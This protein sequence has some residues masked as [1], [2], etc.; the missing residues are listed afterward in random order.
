MEI[1]VNKLLLDK[2]MNLWVRKNANEFAL[3]KKN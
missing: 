2:A 1:P 3:K